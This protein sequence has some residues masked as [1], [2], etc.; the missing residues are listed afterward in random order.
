MRTL[1]LCAAAGGPFTYRGTVPGTT[2]LGLE[3]A[4][5]RFHITSAEFDRAAEILK[6]TLE[7]FAVPEKER[8]QV[9]AAFAAHKTEVVSGM[10]AGQKCPFARAFAQ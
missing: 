8:D 10:H 1:W 2:P 4:H 5:A 9:L 6:S 3:K 7:S